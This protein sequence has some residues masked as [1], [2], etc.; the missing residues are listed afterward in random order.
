MQTHKAHAHINTYSCTQERSATAEKGGGSTVDKLTAEVNELKHK[1]NELRHIARIRQKE[2]T[3]KNDELRDLERDSARTSS[4]NP[5]ARVMQAYV[6]TSHTLICVYVTCACTC[7]RR[8]CVLCK[9][10]AV[11]ACV[12]VCVCVCVCVCVFFCRC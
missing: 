12:R 10:L 2:L 3:S 6:Y 5:L 7:A 9:H 4:D 8:V 1:Y 11:R